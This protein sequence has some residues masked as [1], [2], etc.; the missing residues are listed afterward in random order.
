[1]QKTGTH[2][3]IYFVVFIAALAGLL[4]GFDLGVISGALPFIKSAFNLSAFAE[5]IVT[6]SVLFG[7]AIGAIVSFWLSRYFGRRFSL[8]V[9][10]IIYTLACL[11][12]AWSP[13]VHFLII[14]RF[15][16]GFSVGVATYNAPIYLSEISPAQKRGSIVTVYQL[17]VTIGIVV[18][19]LSDLLFTPS[20]S[21]R[22]MVGIICV[23]AVLMFI[24]ILFLPRSPR[25]LMLSDRRQEALSVL[26]KIHNPEDVDRE[27]SNI[28]TVSHKI[29]LR[30]ILSNNRYIAVV[31]LGVGLQII[32]Q[33][34]G[35]N[36]ML[37]YAPEIF[38]HA[39]FVSHF[40][41]MFATFLIGIVNTIA[42][43]FVI[44]FVETFGRRKLLY[45][46]GSAILLS[47]FTLGL[48]LR[49]SQSLGALTPYFSLFDVFLFII[50]YAVGYGSVVWVLCSEIFPLQGRDVAMSCATTSNWVASGIVGVITLPIIKDFGIA[51]FYFILAVIAVAS[52][53]VVR[54]FVPETKGV[55]LES[56]ENNLMSGKP[57]REIG[58]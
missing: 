25:W 26:K 30:Q 41:Q 48:I 45:F 53:I 29:S 33:F 34:A 46:S 44:R 35:M 57:L 3:F 43:I 16:L 38:A 49:D 8:L 14:A 37:Y 17:M 20:G 9:S 15:V 39:G 55:E 12:S 28:D 19:F 42:T 47:T 11:G 50:G 4:F 32:Q 36:A 51:N 18:A 13:S 5:G 21:W 1:M 52:L 58:V 2:Y 7:S 24:G 10:A 22:W 54:L 31:L 23:P 6:S 56:I 40:S 27:L